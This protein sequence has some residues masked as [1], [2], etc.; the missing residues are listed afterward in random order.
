MKNAKDVIKGVQDMYIQNDKLLI[1]IT[2]DRKKHC[3]KLEPKR[4]IKNED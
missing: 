3:I 2:T 1:I 4:N